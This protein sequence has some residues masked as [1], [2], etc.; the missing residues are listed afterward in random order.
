LV[1]DKE[2]PET[3]EIHISRKPADPELGMRYL[4]LDAT[5]RQTIETYI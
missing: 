4:P 1:Q 5:S 3:F 2:K